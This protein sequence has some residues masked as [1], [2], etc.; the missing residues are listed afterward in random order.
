MLR[1]D[2]VKIQWGKKQTFERVFERK[3][4]KPGL[5]LVTVLIVLPQ[6]SQKETWAQFAKSSMKNEEYNF[7]DGWQDRSSASN[8]PMN[9]KEGQKF[10]NS[11]R[12][13]YLGFSLTSRNKIV[14]V[15]MC[16]KL[17]DEASSDQN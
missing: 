14:C 2:V 15:F 4:G 6:V 8:R 10:L 16:Q 12:S 7:G 5:K 13:L 11:S 9:S 3:W 1:T 17:L